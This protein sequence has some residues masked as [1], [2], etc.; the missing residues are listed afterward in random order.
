MRASG[1]IHLESA[2]REV[3]EYYRI[4][5]CQQ[6][7]KFRQEFAAGIFPKVPVTFT[8][9]KF[10]NPRKCQVASDSL[11]RTSL[12]LLKLNEVAE[13]KFLLLRI[14]EQSYKIE[15]SVVNVVEDHLGYIT[16]L[17]MYHTYIGAFDEVYDIFRVGTMLIVKEPYFEMTKQCFLIR[18]E[19]ETDVISLTFSNE[20]HEIGQAIPWVNEIDLSEDA[21]LV[22]PLPIT[23][24][25]WK[26]RGNDLF[27]R[28]RYY[29]AVEA[30]SRC[31]KYAKGI[32]NDDLYRI[33][34]NNLAA[35]YLK[36]REFESALSTCRQVFIKFPHDKKA[37]YRAGHSAIGFRDY[38]L[39]KDFFQLLFNV[40]PVEG[41]V[42]LKR[43]EARLLESQGNIDMKKLYRTAVEKPGTLI[44]IGNYMGPVELCE[45]S[46]IVAKEDIKAGT[47]I[48]VIKALAAK[49]DDLQDYTLRTGR[50][51]ITLLDKIRHLTESVG[52]SVCKNPATWEK[53]LN[54]LSQNN[55]KIVNFCESETRKE[56]IIDTFELRNLI[57][58]RSFYIED[59]KQNYNRR[60][61]DFR[62]IFGN[63]FFETSSH[64][65]HSCLPNCCYEIFND[66]MV[67][68]TLWPIKV[69]EVLTLNYLPYSL[70][71]EAS[72]RLQLL[73]MKELKCNCNLCQL[74]KAEL[75]NWVQ[76]RD[77]TRDKLYKFKD[78]GPDFWPLIAQ[79]FECLMADMEYMY[80]R[81]KRKILK[82]D[83]YLPCMLLCQC[84]HNLVDHKKL[85][86]VALKLLKILG[87]EVEVL[88]KFT[89]EGFPKELYGTLYLSPEVL[90]VLEMLIFSYNSVL[91]DHL[92][93]ARAVCK[94][95]KFLKNLFTLTTVG[96][97]SKRCPVNHLASRLEKF[98]SKPF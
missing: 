14:L 88:K 38:V 59:P 57:F 69:G 64:F 42:E 71:I 10:Q 77:K 65:K 44:D 28:G 48:V 50:D 92:E 34:N 61:D 54:S 3:G 25:D 7:I 79:E 86:E 32:D 49:F 9:C 11:Q 51:G 91:T 74:D 35:A 23:A 19:S 67:V 55:K 63:G 58:S 87:I 41:L 24:E 66:V 81:S 84:Y 8:D 68:K 46:G 76:K 62:M 95:A 1:A 96:R 45:D 21:L 12:K 73:K 72:E 37:L 80:R 47:V 20:L 36:L 15:N 89:D 26:K 13:G 83:M 78:I 2:L 60:W 52:V 98:T 75:Q 18:V 33:T 16:F 70:K 56:V 85:R 93:E 4:F 17:H 43:V 39:A 90:F 27:A 94:V 5:H 53:I 40:E 82:T 29:L 22:K 30:Y 97:S 6:N 31:I